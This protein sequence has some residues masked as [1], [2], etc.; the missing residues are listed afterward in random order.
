MITCCEVIINS[1]SNK[2]IKVQNLIYLLCRIPIVLF[3]KSVE[4]KFIA[5]Q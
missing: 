4:D 5:L 2:S 3:M 1:R